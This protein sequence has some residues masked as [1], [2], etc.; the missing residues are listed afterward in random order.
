M[1]N[2]NKL[3]NNQKP[4]KLED[5]FEKTTPNKIINSSQIHYHSDN[6]IAK[7]QQEYG[8]KKFIKP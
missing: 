6:I 4:L 5:F 2:I 1:H 7:H 8:H 3:D